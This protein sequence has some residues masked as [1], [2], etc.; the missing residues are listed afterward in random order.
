MNDIGIPESLR[1][2]EKIFNP[3]RA[4]L[5]VKQKGFCG[6]WLL[7]PSS[8]LAFLRFKIN[9]TEEQAGLAGPTLP[10]SNFL[11]VNFLQVQRAKAMLREQADRVRD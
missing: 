6:P 3:H 9:G 1:D 4:L 11:L 8:A 2:G 7:T 5:I 10:K